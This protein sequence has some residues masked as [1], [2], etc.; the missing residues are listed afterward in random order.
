[1]NQTLPNKSKIKKI[2]FNIILRNKKSISDLQT[3]HPII[4]SKHKQSLL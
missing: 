2:A 1:M 3:N 4:H